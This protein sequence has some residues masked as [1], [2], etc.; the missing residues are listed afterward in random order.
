VLLSDGAPVVDVM[1]DA[2]ERAIMPRWRALVGDDVRSKAT[3]DDPDD[4]V[5][6]ADLEAEQIITAGLL[7]LLPGVP[8]IGE[9][10]VAADPSMIDAMSDLPAYWLVDPIDGTRNFV[11]GS[12]DFGVMVALVEGGSVTGG[13]IW[14]P[15]RDVVASA[16]RGGGTFVDGERVDSSRGAPRDIRAMRGWIARTYLPSDVAALLGP[17][18]EVTFAAR[19]PRSAAVGYVS[20]LEGTADVALFWRTH[21][22]DHAPG[23]LLVEEAGGAARRLDGSAYRPGDDGAGLLSVRDERTWEALRAAAFG[24]AEL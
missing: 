18:V 14:L 17:D 21:P 16:T 8:V 11:E 13:W 24:D 9:E 20:L 1:R 5:T 15:V 23:S 4:V 7:A 3:R 2:G 6:V 22:W 12:P 19:P 10:A